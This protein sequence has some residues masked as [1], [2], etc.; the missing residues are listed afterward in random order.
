MSGLC[1]SELDYDVVGVD[2]EVVEM[3]SLVHV[4]RI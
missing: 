4:G 2:G 3:S 1:S